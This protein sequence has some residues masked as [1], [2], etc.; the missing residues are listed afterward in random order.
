MVDINEII[1]KLRAV[2][3]GIGV[4]ALLRQFGTRIGDNPGQ[5]SRTDWIK[6]VKQV[7]VF[8]ANGDKRLRLKNPLPTEI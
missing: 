2:P 4:G 5:T 3:E 8:G 1:N 7:A 6:L